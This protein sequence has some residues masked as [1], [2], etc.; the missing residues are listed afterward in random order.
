MPRL[1]LLMIFGLIA[2]ASLAHAHWT[3][4]P[5]QP[6]WARRGYCQWG[7]G[8]SVNGRVKW[9]PHGFGVDPP[10]AKL[11]LDCGRNLEQTIE[12]MS[13]EARAIGEGGGLKRQ[14]YICS[15]TIWWRSE[16]PKAPQ[17]EQCTIV[18]PDGKR[19]LLYNNPERY[20]G[21][22]SSPIW[23]QYMKGRVDE[24]MASQSAGGGTI[25]SI[26]F[27]NASDYN[28]YCADCR[29]KFKAWS[30]EKYG[31][32]MDLATPEK[33]PN[34][35]FLKQWF[36]ADMA[37]EFFKQ[38]K[39]YITQ[40]YGSDILISPNISIGYGWSDYLVNHGAT[41]LV[42][43]E[44]GLTL[45]PTDSTIFKY[46]LGLAAS[47]GKTTGQLLGL[48][49][50]LRRERALA[51]DKG[52]EMGI[53]ESFVYPEEHKLALAEAA[54]TGGTDC[55]SF[56]LREQKVFASDA[57]YQVQIR[58]AISQYADFQKQ[59][60]AWWDRARPGAKVAVVQGI[61][62][63]LADRSPSLLRATCEALGRA[64]LPYEVLVEEDLTPE[65]LAGY[66]LVILPR[67]RLLGRDRCEALLE[68]VRQGGAVVLGGESAVADELGRPYETAQLPEIARAAA[69]EARAIGKGKLLNCGAARLDEM[70]SAE[71]AKALEGVAGPLECRVQA[72]A[73]RVFANIL[74]SADGHTRT[75]H[76]VNSDV[77]YDA[78]PSKD[79]RDDS[80][81]A[82]ARSFLA[83]TN[84]R[85][86]K[87]LLV[88]DVAAVKGYQLRFFGSTCGI[89]TDK[90]S[91]VVSFNGQPIR[92]YK[93][94]E[95]NEAGW[96][97]TPVPDGLMKPVNEI[98]FQAT[99]AP[100]GHPDWFAL[101]ID[102]AA[103]TGRSS[104]SA[105]EGKTWTQDDL[106]LDAGT[107]TGEFLVRLGPVGDPSAVAKPEDFMGKLHVHP[108]KD[109][110]V[111]VKT[112]KA[113]PARVCSPDGPEQALK[114]S[115]EGA[116][117]VY[118]V[119][120]VYLYS[121]LVLTQ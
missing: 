41:D 32:E 13:P 75:I 109:V 99:G 30:R 52:N 36:D 8:A 113:Q 16:F 22:Y 104:W 79:I 62:T 100:S 67:V 17:L 18:G 70:P 57:P 84:T 56:G 60:L 103:K 11:L 121:V 112:D 15:K 59:H 76:L 37:V 48:S 97:E 51:L 2:T 5:G 33:Y 50:M 83:S 63:Q 28:C 98:I 87:T 107:Q 111:L 3:D 105:D 58:Q 118:R 46:K 94:S 93:G 44:E 95:L 81:V 90:F 77:T 19:V 65:Q 92:T 73:P 10:N 29:A 72:T 117:A 115:R 20:G 78:L 55:V 101:K 24:L 66:Q 42:F 39:A 106:S 88:P 12:Y 40:K 86:R 71:L 108:A 85:I 6:S 68:Y 96:F 38:V 4:Q 69:G 25:H 102:T 21:C 34:F 35:A 9:L 47:H 26:F 45:P 64:G 14:P 43:I 1:R 53:Q 54:A 7:H 82:G 91:L 89:A 119:P 31:Q 23:L 110:R 27:D 120:E 61:M 74:T 49:E 114:P 116:Y 80:G